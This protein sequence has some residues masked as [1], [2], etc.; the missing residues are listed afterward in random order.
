MR[1]RRD[2]R[3]SGRVTGALIGVG[4]L[5]AVVMAFMLAVTTSEA[6]PDKA[7]FLVNTEQRFVVP[8][9]LPG[10]YVFFALPDGTGD[11]VWMRVQD[12]ITWGE[13]RHEDHPYHDFDLPQTPE[14]DLFVFYGEEVTL[15]RSLLYP[16]PS[17]W[18]ESGHWRY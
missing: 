4:G 12:R 17:R 1:S 8:A 16:P 15:L 9:P 10:R 7:L 6:I 13:L 11:D 3:P 18:D 5:I 2:L 14:W